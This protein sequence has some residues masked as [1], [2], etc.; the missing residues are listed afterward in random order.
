MLQD[1]KKIKNLKDIRSFNS[2]KILFH[3][4][5]VSS[6]FHSYVFSRKYIFIHKQKDNINFLKIFPFFFSWFVIIFV[7]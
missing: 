7:M 2:S 1:F 6:L 3:I 5:N 4:E